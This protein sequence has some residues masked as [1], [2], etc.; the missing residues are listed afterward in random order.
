LF[1]S[2]ITV[3]V[4]KLT[5]LQNSCQIFTLMTTFQLLKLC[6][7]QMVNGGWKAQ[8]NRKKRNKQLGQ[9]EWK[10]F[11]KHQKFTGKFGKTLSVT[12]NPA[13]TLQT[14]AIIS[15]RATCVFLVLILKILWLGVGVSLLVVP[16]MSVLLITPPT[17]VIR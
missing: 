8:K 15:S 9:R 4:V 17:L 16:S 6:L 10:Q 1:Q 7:I 3:P 14:F 12:S 11:E 2:T 13:W 5:L